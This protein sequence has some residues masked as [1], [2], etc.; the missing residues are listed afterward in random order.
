MLNF[1]YLATTVPV[2]IVNTTTAVRICPL[3]AVIIRYIN[4]IHNLRLFYLHIFFFF[5]QS[6]PSMMSC[7]F[8]P[9]APRKSRATFGNLTK[10]HPKKN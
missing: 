10:Y 3:Q 4:L 6:T 2:I 8:P 5:Y 9:A 7:N 1:F